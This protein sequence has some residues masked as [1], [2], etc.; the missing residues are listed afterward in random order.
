M[1]KKAPIND[2]SIV[3]KLRSGIGGLAV[4]F[5]AAMTA[6][7]ALAL[8]KSNFSEDAF[9]LTVI[10]ILVAGA[11]ATIYMFCYGVIMQLLKLAAKT[12]QHSIEL[13]KERAVLYEINE[14]REKEL[15]NLLLSE[16][17]E[18]EQPEPERQ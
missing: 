14:R 8:N 7:T 12:Q 13:A 18:N 11:G 17:H 9:L 6:I 4:I 5:T 1:A 15:D 3:A 2:M 16:K 10:G